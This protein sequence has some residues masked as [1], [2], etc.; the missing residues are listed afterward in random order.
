MPREGSRARREGSA[1]DDMTRLWRVGCEQAIHVRGPDSGPGS[2]W[3]A[4]TG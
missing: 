3:W 4:L 1:D 2:M